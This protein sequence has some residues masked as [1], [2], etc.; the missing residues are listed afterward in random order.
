MDLLDFKDFFFK[1]NLCNG[2]GVFHQFFSLLPRAFLKHS[3]ELVYTLESRRVS[4]VLQG[5]SLLW[6][7]TTSVGTAVHVLVRVFD[8][9][10]LL[11]HC[12][13]T[14]TTKHTPPNTR[15]VSHVR[16][17]Q[18][19]KDSCGRTGGGSFPPGVLGEVLPVLMGVARCGHL[20]PAC[21]LSSRAPTS[22]SRMVVW[23]LAPGSWCL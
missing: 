16:G 22:F 4:V 21:A 19:H 5:N 18:Q 3:A 2:K 23:V 12:H 15:Q 20:G 8:L 14:H 17:K 1:K 10:H 13:Q 7:V 6:S 9:S 11:R